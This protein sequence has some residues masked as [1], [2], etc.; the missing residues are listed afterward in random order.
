V[1]VATRAKKAESSHHRFIGR[2]LWAAGRTHRR[3]KILKNFYKKYYIRPVTYAEEAPNVAGAWVHELLGRGMDAYQILR[4]ELKERIRAARLK[5]VLVRSLFCCTGV[6]GRE[7]LE[8][9][10]SEGRGPAREGAR[11][12]QSFLQ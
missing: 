6:S 4:R 9:Q 11:Q 2:S 1:A 12:M 5:A 7:I 10:A 8:R 3:Y